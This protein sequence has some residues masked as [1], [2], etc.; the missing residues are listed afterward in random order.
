MGRPDEQII[1]IWQLLTTDSQK[2]LQGC[3]ELPPDSLATV[4]AFLEG[5][6]SINVD[7]NVDPEAENLDENLDQDLPIAIAA[8]GLLG[9]TAQWYQKLIDKKECPPH[10]YLKLAAALAYLQSL[11]RYAKNL[12]LGTAIAKEIPK[13]GHRLEKYELKDDTAQQ[14]VTSFPHSSLALKFSKLLL[15]QLH[16]V[17][18]KQGAKDLVER[19]T[20]GT[21]PY[22]CQI[23]VEAKDPPPTVEIFQ[24]QLILDLEK[25]EGIEEY[26]SHKI[27][28][29]PQAQVYAENFT[30]ADIYVPLEGKPSDPQGGIDKKAKSVDIG[31]WVKSTL[32]DKSERGIFLQGASGLGKSIFCR[33]FADWVRQE[34]YPVYIPVFLQLR[35]FAIA[36]QHPVKTSTGTPFKNLEKTLTT[37]LQ[38]EALADSLIKADWLRDQNTRYLFICDGLEELPL[39]NKADLLNFLQQITDF[40]QTYQGCGHRFLLASRLLGGQPDYIFLNWHCLELQPMNETQQEQWLQRW[41]TLKGQGLEFGEFLANCPSQI[42]QLAIEPLSLYFLAAM[43]SDRALN[44]ESFADFLTS[45]ISA[46][47]FLYQLAADWAIYK[48]SQFLPTPEQSFDPQVCRH[49]FLAVSFCLVQSGGI[50][51]TLQEV[52]DRFTTSQQS[53]LNG[54]RAAKKFLEELT[55]HL[56]EIPL[57]DFLDKSLNKSSNNSLNNPWLTFCKDKDKQDYY[58]GFHHQSFGEFLWALQLRSSILDWMTLGK[59]QQEFYVSLEQMDWQIYHLLGYGNLTPEVVTSLMSLLKTSDEFFPTILW[60]RLH[61]FYLRWYH[62]EF[63]DALRDNLPQRK[64]WQL[65]APWLPL[66]KDIVGIRHIDIFTGLNIMILLWELSRCPQESPKKPIRFYACGQIDTENFSA[67]RLLEIINYSDTCGLDTFSHTFRTFLSGADLAGID[68]HG[69]NLQGVDLSRA[70]LGGANL[71]GVDFRI[72]DLKLGYLSGA[73]LSRADL[74]GADLS[75]ADLS[76]ADLSGADL[77]GADLSGADLSRADLSRTNLR[78]TNLSGTNLSRS[79]L[80]DVNL[81]GT[82]LSGASLSAANLSGANLSRSNLSCA[83]LTGANL[84]RTYLSRAYLS[85]ANLN[86]AYLSRAYLSRAYLSDTIVGAITWDKSTNWDEIR[87]WE[88]VIGIPDNLK[89]QLGL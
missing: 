54:D 69:K 23:L 43:H 51:P 71:R 4:Q 39:R 7:P 13:A 80:S 52:S 48:F 66:T 29:L 5:K 8:I 68:L 88:T 62:G 77:S 45:E 86:G 85:G 56:E 58:L 53:H 34:L 9:V 16:L 14:L 32:G 65:H 49:F 21:H 79:N 57:E 1:K 10:D 12:P 63:I 37:I 89:Q 83:D 44:L 59:R 78:H 55:E 38:N 28:L 6:V 41:M 35:D 2:L 15:P 64:L 30:Y 33:I 22:L 31:T 20:W 47:V 87:G 46:K 50:Y 25:F 27:A 61:N 17:L 82:N 24:R 18:G 36:E 67:T 26:L 75:G 42:Q 40:Q 60:Q 81:N 11:G 76:G 74:S 72:A 70:D 84:S 73:D 3:Q 19:V